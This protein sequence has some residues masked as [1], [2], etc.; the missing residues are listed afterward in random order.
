MPTTTLCDAIKSRTLVCDGAMGTQL[1]L[2]GLK[3]G[4]CGERWLIDRPADVEAIH[5]AYADAGADLITTN[6]FG[7]SR[8][9]LGRHGHADELGAIN[10]AGVAVA[11]RGAPAAFVLADVGPLGALLEP[12]GDITEA[13]AESA[14]EEQIAALTEADAVLVETMVDPNEAAIAI[15]AVRRAA[16]K[17]PVVATFAFGAG[18]KTMMGTT[19]D[20]CVRTAVDAG[21]SIVGAN[22]GAG[23]SL[24]DYVLLARDLVRAA[25]GVHVIVQPNAGMPV[26]RDGKLVYNATPDDV[27]RVAVQLVEAGVSIVGGCCGTTPA[28]IAAVAKA[29]KR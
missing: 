14:F 26:E 13:Q 11:R 1:F 7:A 18:L 9:A 3:S 22:C 5:R 4:A 10:R 15:R 29:L 8:F 21:A 28:H 2:R 16:P 27:A 23:L 24:A 20:E 19:A 6:T 12:Y 25:S 17:L